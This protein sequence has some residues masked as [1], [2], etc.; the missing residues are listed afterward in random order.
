[1]RKDLLSYDYG[2][3]IFYGYTDMNN[4]G[5]RKN[6]LIYPEL[7]YK[8]IGT[9]FNVWNGVGS[10]HKESFYQKAAVRDF[11]EAGLSFKQQLP[12]KIIYKDEFV[13]VYYFDFL[14]EDKIVLELKVR[15]YF[16]KKDI[17]QAFSYLKAKKL[18]LGII[19]HFT[20]TGVRIKR[21]VNVN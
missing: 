3:R 1:L 17:T 9:L 20:K 2:L 18:K 16:S 10:N 6:N 11:K 8:I 4:Y 19:A 15:D 12:A 13:G 21:V 7:S 5:L 14:V